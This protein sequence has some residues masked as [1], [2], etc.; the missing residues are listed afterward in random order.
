M[1]HSVLEEK[2]INQMYKIIKNKNNKLNIK[3]INNITNNII[4]E[5]YTNEEVNIYSKKD[6]AIGTLNKIFLNKIKSDD[7]CKIEET[8][9]KI[10]NMNGEIDELINKYDYIKNKKKDRC[11]NCIIS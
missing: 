6:V 9:D 5:M 8:K 11:S 4:D 2:E 1:N 10:N 7:S 3:N